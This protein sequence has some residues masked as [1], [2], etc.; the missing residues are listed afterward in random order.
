MLRYFC[1]LSLS[2]SSTKDTLGAM[3]FRLETQ[4]NPQKQQPV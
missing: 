3:N 2:A 1:E 4:I